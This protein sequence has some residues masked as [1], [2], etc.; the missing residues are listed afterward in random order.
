M[1]H[2]S[3]P[4][5]VRTRAEQPSF[6]MASERHVR[7]EFFNLRNGAK[8]GPFR[9]AGDLVVTSFR[10]SFE[11]SDGDATHLVRELDQVV[12]PDG[13]LVEVDCQVD[14]T[15]QFIWAPAFAGTEHT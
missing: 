3:I 8:L 1:Q 2:F 15:L 6:H 14:G 7:I 4:E 12:I 11:V 5:L 9:Y 13:S 10:G